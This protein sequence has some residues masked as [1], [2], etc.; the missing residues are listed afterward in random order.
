MQIAQILAEAEKSNSSLTK[1]LLKKIQQINAEKVELEKN[2]NE[3]S[4]IRA[5]TLLQNQLSNINKEI[6]EQDNS[7][8]N[9][10]SEKAMKNI[11]LAKLCGEE[12]KL[13]ALAKAQQDNNARYAEAIES[14][15]AQITNLN[16]EK[17]R[18]DKVVNE[19]YEEKSDFDELQKE[20]DEKNNEFRIYGPEAEK[21]LQKVSELEPKVRDLKKAI[22]D[23]EPAIKEIWD[24]LENDNFDIFVGHK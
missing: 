11:E 2:F 1:A 12:Q 7:F 5:N 21:K 19:F 18:R 3:E 13:V 9:L 17:K 20:Y 8:K 15:N 14:I 23:V 22:K 16:E 6:K 4:A 24:L 10:V